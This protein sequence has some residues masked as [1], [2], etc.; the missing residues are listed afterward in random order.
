MPKEIVCKFYRKHKNSCVIKPLTQEGKKQQCCVFNGDG[1]CHVKI[2]PKSR[3]P[4]RPIGRPP[5]T[6]K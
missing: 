5:K 1:Y 4:K 3:L 2:I 6:K